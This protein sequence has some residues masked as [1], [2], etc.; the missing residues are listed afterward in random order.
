MIN[1]SFHILERE[2][3]QMALFKDIF[4]NSNS[5]DVSRDHWA[6]QKDTTDETYDMKIK[7]LQ[8]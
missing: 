8:F 1:Y 7:K 4:P 5:T 6:D 3:Q 2:Y